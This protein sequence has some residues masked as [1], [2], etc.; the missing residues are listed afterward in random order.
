MYKA[1][2][3]GSKVEGVRVL[4]LEGI[5]FRIQGRGCKGLGFIRD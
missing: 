1:L 2:R 5:E 3:L 4:G